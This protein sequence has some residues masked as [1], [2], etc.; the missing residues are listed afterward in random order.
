MEWFHK[1]QAYFKEQLSI[2]NLLKILLIL[3][4]LYFLYLTSNVWMS[5]ARVL[6]KILIPFV[7]GFFIAYL[8]HP[9]IMALQKIKISRKI[10]IPLV[11]LGLCVLLIGIFML[12]VPL[13]YDKTVELINSMISGVSWLY[14]QYMEMNEY[15]P[16]ILVTQIVQQIISTLNDTKSWMPNLPVLLPAVIA[17]IL[18]F[19]TDAIFAIVISIYVLFDYDRIHDSIFRIAKAFHSE[20]PFYLSAVDDELGSYL[21]SLLM[22]MVI[23]FFE[24]SILY[25]LIGHK[26]AVVIALL[27]AI[28]LIV[29]YFGATLANCV[30]ILTALTLPAVNV[31]M[32]IAGIMILSLVDSYLIAP[33]V[34]SHS[35]KVPP[36]WTLLCVFAGGILAGPVGIMVSIP[37]FMSLRVILNLFRFRNEKYDAI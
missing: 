2:R 35:S 5:W 28:G 1:I 30:G 3:L 17:S 22:L 15:S 12:V 33:V 8:L 18:G 20:L 36:L 24:Y 26:S 11:S 21:R 4:I 14:D 25:M 31:L 16:N 29:P 10:A 27:T 19:L 7:V 37:L 6:W 32:L 9:L 34:H 13:I 23:K